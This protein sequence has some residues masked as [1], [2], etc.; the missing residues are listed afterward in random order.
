MKK[1][2]VL[3]SNGEENQQTS[4]TNSVCEGQKSRLLRSL[5]LLLLILPTENRSLLRD[6]FDLLHLAANHSCVNK[7]SAENLATLF[8]PLLLCP[9]K[10]RSLSFQ[11]HFYK[12]FIFLYLIYIL[13]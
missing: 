12:L 6:V 9:R 5:Q 1:I 7:M 2:K 8:T 11:V 3:S 10:V 4:N 13:T